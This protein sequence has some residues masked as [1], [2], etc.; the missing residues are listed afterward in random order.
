MGA[1]VGITPVKAMLEDYQSS[2]GP[3][4]VVVRASSPSEI[5]LLDEVVSLAAERGARIHLILGHRGAGW[6]TQDGPLSLAEVIPGLSDCDVF[7][8]GPEAWS[9]AVKGDAIRCG[10]AKG[11]IHIEEYAW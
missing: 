8:C 2:E 11:A 3:C 10:V 5:P 6:S 7:V 4:H 1:G 9:A